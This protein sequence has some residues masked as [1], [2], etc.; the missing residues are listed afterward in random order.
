MFIR[1]GFGIPF[2]K[3]TVWRR[4]NRGPVKKYP[5]TRTCFLVSIRNFMFCPSILCR[6]LLFLSL[7][8]SRFLADYFMLTRSKSTERERERERERGARLLHGDT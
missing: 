7:S 2:A 4:K 5:E 8:L 1:A 6:S 3:P